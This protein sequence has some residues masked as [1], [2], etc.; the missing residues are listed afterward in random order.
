MIST[1]S[2]STNVTNQNT[3]PIS[4]L[5]NQKNMQM[6]QKEETLQN[7]LNTVKQNPKFIKLLVYSLNSLE[8]FVSPPNRDIRIN[9]K[10]IIKCKL[11]VI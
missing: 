3:K 2:N 6:Q 8:S 11:D 9:A 4:K 10:I 7:V 5:Q 1:N